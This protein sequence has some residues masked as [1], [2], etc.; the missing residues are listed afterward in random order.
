MCLL[1]ARFACKDT[2]I[3][4]IKING[5]SVRKCVRE[6]MMRRRRCLRKE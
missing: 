2:F 3:T 5:R 4:G 1:T 6:M